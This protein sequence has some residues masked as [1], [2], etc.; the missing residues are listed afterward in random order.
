MTHTCFPTLERAACSAMKEPFLVCVFLWWVGQQCYAA[1]G[2]T[3]GAGHSRYAV[4]DLGRAH[5]GQVY[6]LDAISINNRGQIAYAVPVSLLGHHDPVYHSYLWQNGRKR[7]IGT[8][9]GYQNT[10]AVGLNDLGE[11]VGSVS[12]PQRNADGLPGYINHAFLWKQGV[13]HDLGLS[14]VLAHQSV[15]GDTSAAAVNNRGV[16]VGS[17]QVWVPRLP[18]D[19]TSTPYLF[20]SQRGEGRSAGHG[21]AA[22]INQQEQVVGTIS[23]RDGA[24]HALLWSHGRKRD[25]GT[26]GSFSLESE[27]DGLNDKHQV[28]GSS[29]TDVVTADGDNV[30]HA[31]LWQRGRMHDLDALHRRQGSG[32]R[33]IDDVGRIV[34]YYLTGEESHACLWFSEYRFDLNRAVPAAGGWVLEDA[35]GIN[36]RGQIVGYGRRRGH[37]HFFLLTPR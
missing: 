31:F 23:S 29:E 10:F 1:P 8:L 20:F 13:M 2:H 21:A 22:A 36:S 19:F 33:A 5:E 14:A 3:Y 30:S 34:G 32:A 6:G 18:G 24:S 7:D 9:P 28:V 25:L 37:R 15:T 4:T 12:R 26:L 17:F 16:V 35:Y 27:A 11:I